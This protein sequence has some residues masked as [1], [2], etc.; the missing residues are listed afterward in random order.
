MILRF[1]NVGRPGIALQRRYL[2]DNSSNT[3]VVKR[4]RKIK[5]KW[6]LIGAATV[7]TG[8]YTL[9]LVLPDTRAEYDPKHYYSDWKVGFLSI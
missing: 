5:F 1:F 7:G 2:A 9:N 4:R 3:P 8:A 6:L